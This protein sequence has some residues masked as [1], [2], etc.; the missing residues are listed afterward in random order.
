MDTPPDKTPGLPEMPP[1]T[2]SPVSTPAGPLT[3]EERQWGMFCHLSALIGHLLLGFGHIVGPLIIWLVKKD[4][5]PFVNQEGK[6]SLNFQLSCT[7]YAIVSLV[8]CFLGLPVFLL[9]MLF[10]IIVVIMA[11][12]DVSNGKP[13]RY[14]L[15]IRFIA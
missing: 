15:C 1:Q 13:Y 9:V 8:F 4:Q 10:D 11:C 7:L 3:P 2:P 12:I 14:P 6:E 5:M